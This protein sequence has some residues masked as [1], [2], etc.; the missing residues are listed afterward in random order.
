V[1]KLRDALARRILT[2]VDGVTETGVTSDDRTRKIPGNLHLCFAD[3]D[4]EALLFLLEREAG[5][6]ASAASACTSG[7]QEPSHVLAA[8]GVPRDLAKGSL[9]LSLGPTTTSGDIDRVAAA[10][11]P[12]VA[13]L[14]R[15]DR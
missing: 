8:M 3:V 7:A 9:R 6:C 14:R 13:R 1:S 11:P 10:V 12:A 4:S 15:L 5:V 2:T